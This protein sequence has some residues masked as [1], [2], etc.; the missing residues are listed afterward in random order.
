MSAQLHTHTNIHSTMKMRNA[1]TSSSRRYLSIGI[2]AV[3]LFM[4][5]QRIIAVM[6]SFIIKNILS[7]NLHVRT[8]EILF[9]NFQIQS[10]FRI[11]PC[12]DKKEFTAIRIRLIYRIKE[13]RFRGRY[14]SITPLPRYHDNPF[15]FFQF[16][17]R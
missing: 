15:I 8:I 10:L 12:K 2:R 1:S 4:Q 13:K 11:N 5:Q 16:C 9:P 3:C 17:F 6:K 14:A 7:L